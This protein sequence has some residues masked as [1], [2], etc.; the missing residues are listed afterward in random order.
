VGK[1]LD[2][3][4]GDVILEPVGELE[5]GQCNVGDTCPTQLLRGCTPEAPTKDSIKY[6]YNGARTTDVLY[7]SENIRVA[8]DLPKE[9]AYGTTGYAARCALCHATMSAAGKGASAAQA[10]PGPT[11]MYPSSL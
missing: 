4:I 6:W 8:N 3:Q 1:Y 2:F 7:Q 9:L 11:C 5:A 10:D